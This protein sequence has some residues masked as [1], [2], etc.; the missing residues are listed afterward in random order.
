MKYMECIYCGKKLFKNSKVIRHKGLTGN[1]CSLEC[2]A[3]NS[4]LFEEDI[5]TDELVAD[6]KLCNNID[7]NY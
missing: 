7:W 1:Y 5:L 3:L 2:A 4:N 6:D